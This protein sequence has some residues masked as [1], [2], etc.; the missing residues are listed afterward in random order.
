MQR[1]SITIVSLA[2]FIGIK[3]VFI[4][5][6]PVVETMGYVERCGRKNIACGFN[7][8]N[9]RVSTTII[10]FARFIGIK[11]VFINTFP[12]LKPGLY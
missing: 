7:R 8:R 6:F 5:M 1:V 9:A 4:D 2:R 12:W 3:N 11:N 10:N